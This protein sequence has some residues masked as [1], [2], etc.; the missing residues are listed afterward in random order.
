MDNRDSV[1]KRFW[2]QVKVNSKTTR[3]PPIVN[4]GEVFRS[5]GE[6][7]ANLFN[8]YFASNFS[9]ASDYNVL[10]NIT[11]SNFESEFSASEIY[12]V[13]S[14]LNSRKAAGPDDIHSVVLGGW[15]PP[16]HPRLGP[17]LCFPSQHLESC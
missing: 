8:E 16:H 9:T 10:P 14:K 2:G 17:P 5:S 11:E 7:Q 15:P 13:L 6:E 3:I 12:D 1:S 4:N